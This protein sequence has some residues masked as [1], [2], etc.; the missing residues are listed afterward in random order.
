MRIGEIASSAEYRLNEQFQ[1]LAIFGAKF[2]F[3][4]LEKIL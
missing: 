4:K 3:S 2:W 1:N